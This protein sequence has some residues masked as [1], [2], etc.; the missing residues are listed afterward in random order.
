[1]NCFPLS[2][3]SVSDFREHPANAKIAASS[4]NTPSFRIVAITFPFFP[5]LPASGAHPK[6]HAPPCGTDLESRLIRKF[7]S[8]YQRD[9]LKRIAFVVWGVETE[10]RHQLLH[11]VCKKLS[12]SP[13][14]SG[15]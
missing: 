1:M 12:K 7:D 9:H 4:V 11:R 5:A 13:K 3:S 15:S 8:T 10:A 6:Q 2:M 14:R